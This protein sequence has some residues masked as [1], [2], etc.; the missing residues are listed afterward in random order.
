[1]VA[2]V[3][4]NFFDFLGDAAAAGTSAAP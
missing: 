1:M 3:A 2:T 4:M